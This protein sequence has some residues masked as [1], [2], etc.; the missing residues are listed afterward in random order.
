MKHALLIAM[1]GCLPWLA[2][3]Q[4]AGSP[5]IRTSGMQWISFLPDGEDCDNP[6][7]QPYTEWADTSVNQRAVLLHSGDPLELWTQWNPLPDWELV[8]H[9]DR[10]TGPNLPD[11]AEL[12]GDE[13]DTTLTKFSTSQQS[14][15]EKY[16]LTLYRIHPE[17]GNPEIADWMHV[18]VMEGAHG[19]AYPLHHGFDQTNLSVSAPQDEL[20]R[21]KVTSG[22]LF[23]GNGNRRSDLNPTSEKMLNMCIYPAYGMPNDLS[24]PGASSRQGDGYL[25]VY[26]PAVSTVTGLENPYSTVC[27]GFN[28]F[29][30]DFCN[31]P[32][33]SFAEA[34][35][36]DDYLQHETSICS[37]V[38]VNVHPT[39]L[40]G[41]EFY[42]GFSFRIPVSFI[43]HEMVG[44]E[45]ELGHNRREVVAEFLQ[46]GWPIDVE[47]AG[48]PCSPTFQL[49]YLGDG[50][51]GIQYGVKGY[52]R[53]AFGP[54]PCEKGAWVDV[55]MR[56]RWADIYST[57]MTIDSEAGLFEL[58]LNHGEGYLKQCLTPA[59][60]Y[61]QD[62]RDFGEGEDALRPF[63]PSE[64][65]T[66]LYGA[67]LV[68]PNP[69]YLSLKSKR[70]VAY[71]GACGLDFTSSVDFDELRMGTA[72]EEVI[73][74]GSEVLQ[75]TG[76]CDAPVSF[77]QNKQLELERNRQVTVFPNPCSD[78]RVTVRWEEDWSPH[79]VEI[80]D[81][82]GRSVLQHQTDL[83]DD[84]Q[85]ELHL[86]HL[87]PGA[88]LVRLD[89]GNRVQT[90]TLVIR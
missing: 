15:W 75:G 79:T 89:A 77:T 51:M 62:K 57:N 14:L 44:P 11:H 81:L 33:G 52:N 50:M 13:V 20:G 27:E 38:E 12:S 76:P 83:M 7:Y 9:L 42:Y 24:K 82:N 73:V 69:A 88:Y 8:W 70:A 58:W 6:S 16:L 18:H 71:N 28:P 34:V 54:W 61:Y 48:Y 49:I 72:L 65:Q 56:I 55:A 47:T 29:T 3:S 2:Q 19:E 30:Y 53:C 63:N 22:P 80:L 87:P 68:N 90:E 43:E 40:V 4:N 35:S 1:L 59:T 37:N 41:E 31:D 5:I 74:P 21:G 84:H 45:G 36:Y 17:T 32:C 25:R 26:N 67:N 23:S 64:D 66:T 60:E 85:A 78:G 46:P 10:L 39:H 86:P